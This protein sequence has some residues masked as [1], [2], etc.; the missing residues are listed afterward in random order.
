MGSGQGCGQRAMGWYRDRPASNQAGSYDVI[1][2]T[3]F[4]A[5]HRPMAP[6]GG[7]ALNDAGRLLLLPTRLGP[8]LLLARPGPVGVVY[9]SV[10]LCWAVEWMRRCDSVNK[11]AFEENVYKES[12]TLL[13]AVWVLPRPSHQR[14]GSDAQLIRKDFWSTGQG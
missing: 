3:G 6:R 1:M 10:C 13:L 12:E 2:H 8:G 11:P 14:H 9:S 4:R 5:M 7:S